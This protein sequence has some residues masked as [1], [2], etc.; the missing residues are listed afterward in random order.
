[1]RSRTRRDVGRHRKSPR[2]TDNKTQRKYN[3]THRNLE[4]RKEN[5]KRR[6]RGKR[7]RGKV[8]ATGKKKIEEEQGQKTSYRRVPETRDRRK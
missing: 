6:R 7:G 2:N 3:R 1:M 4:L 8:V 5:M